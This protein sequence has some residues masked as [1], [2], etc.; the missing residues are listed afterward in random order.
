V[1]DRLLELDADRIE[2]G[3]VLRDELRRIISRHQSYPDANWSLPEVEVDR[4][5]RAFEN[6]EPTEAVSKHAWLFSGYPRLP[7]TAGRSW[8]ERQKE[9]GERR[10]VAVQEVHAELGPAGLERLAAVTENP[11]T[12][13]VS[14]GRSELLPD[15]EEDA[16]LTKTL[17]SLDEH[18]KD[19]GCGFVIG[20]HEKEGWDW[21]E[22]KMSE[23]GEGWPETQ[24]ARFLTCLPMEDRL[25]QLLDRTDEGTR[26]SYW[27]LANPYRL[28][29]PNDCAMVTERLLEH[30]RPF[31][32]VETLALYAEQ[33]DTNIPSPLIVRALEG[34]GTSPPPEQIDLDLF[35][36]SVVELL[37]PLYESDEIDRQTLASLEWVFLYVLDQQG[38]QPKLLHEE[39]SRSPGF[40]A[41]VIE[42]VYKPETSEGSELSESEQQRA[43]KANELLQNW[44]IVPGTSED[45]TIDPGDLDAWISTARIAAAARD[46]ATSADHCIGRVLAASPEGADGAW[47]HEAVRNV[48][49]SLQSDDV[50]KAFRGQVVS[51]RGV[52]SKGYLEGGDQE[53]E[54]AERYRGYSDASRFRWPRTSAVLDEIAD[55]YDAWARQADAEAELREDS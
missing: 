36:H 42:L 37:D 47:P 29:N 45:A 52:Y 53:R 46:R 21:A 19:L 51:S 54:L 12:V 24:K 20:R 43:L 31:T 16:F 38:R 41:D 44:R 23:V 48:I 11:V 18:A 8:A 35:G 50:D 34:A 27:S 26:A 22:K 25:Y 39:L 6:L 55:F 4:L 17:G 2:D 33:V 28:S 5:V 7:R 10:A 13:G 40:F 9:L 1:V 15:E 3:A 49:D 32:A 14:V 30:G